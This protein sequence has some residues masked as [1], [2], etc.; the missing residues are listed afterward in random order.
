MVL[1]EKHISDYGQKFVELQEQLN[2]ER[3]YNLD[4]THALDEL[5]TRIIF[6]MH[7]HP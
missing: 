4:L 1:M 5:Y 6:H 2:C 3:E 7:P